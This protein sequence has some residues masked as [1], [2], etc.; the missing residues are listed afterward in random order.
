MP[1]KL[2]KCSFCGKD[3]EIV[4][5]LIVAKK[6]TICNYCI[7]TCLMTIMEEAHGKFQKNKQ[8]IENT[9]KKRL[10]QKPPQQR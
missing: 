5:I 2:L 10:P 4:R 9:T 8:P 7:I 6:A 1:K 3:E